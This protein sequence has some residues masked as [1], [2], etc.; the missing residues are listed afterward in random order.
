HYSVKP[1]PQ[2]D[3]AVAIAAAPAQASA[4]EGASSKETSL[5]PASAPRKRYGEAMELLNC[6]RKLNK[7]PV[8]HIEILELCCVC[9]FL[10]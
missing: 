9:K 10:A 6:A 4:E 7:D 1:T 3:T 8:V 5:V 2:K